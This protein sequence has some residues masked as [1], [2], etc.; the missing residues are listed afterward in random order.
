M[1]IFYKY[2][3]FQLGIESLIPFQTYLLNIYVSPFV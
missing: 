3:D 2:S 1:E